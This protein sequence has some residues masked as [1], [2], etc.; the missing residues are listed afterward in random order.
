M[1]RKIMARLHTR[2]TPEQKKFLEKKAKR[3][4]ITE[5]AALRVMIDYFIKNNA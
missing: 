5:G 1:Q 3:Y 2:I 4:K